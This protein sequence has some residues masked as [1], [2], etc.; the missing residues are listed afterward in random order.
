MGLKTG[1]I[2]RWKREGYSLCKTVQSHRTESHRTNKSNSR[3]EFLRNLHRSSSCFLATTE[4]CNLET[5]PSGTFGIYRE[6]NFVQHETSRHCW[7][8]RHPFQGHVGS[9][10]DPLHC[11]ACL[12]EAACH[13]LPLTRYCL[14]CNTRIFG[15]VVTS[16]I[17]EP[18]GVV[19]GSFVL[20]CVSGSKII[21]IMIYSVSHV[22]LNTH[23]MYIQ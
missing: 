3:K 22:N 13:R 14:E 20:H 7:L 17:L 6:L 1:H 18:C 11:I 21:Y 9:F 2:G 10:L 12:P 23:E 4:T 19:S 15:V 8:S 16:S 5:S